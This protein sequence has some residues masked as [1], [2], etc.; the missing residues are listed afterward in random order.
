M[1]KKKKA[2]CYFAIYSLNCT[3]H[4]AYFDSYSAAERFIAKV[5]RDHVN[6]RVD[7]WADFIVKGDIERA[8]EGGN[9]YVI[10]DKRK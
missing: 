2:D 9:S 4:I 1:K 10:V 3:P 5:Y 8:Y 7:N 6:N